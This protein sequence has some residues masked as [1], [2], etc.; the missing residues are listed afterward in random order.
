MVV[1]IEYDKLDGSRWLD[2]TL[3]LQ[4]CT[5]TILA[6]PAHPLIEMAVDRVMARLRRLAWKQGT[7]VSGI[8]AS[9]KEV[10]DS[11]G[12]A[13]FTEVVLEGLAQST[14]T[15][16]SHLNLTGLKTARLISDVLIL[17]INAFGSGQAH[18][19][20]GSPD[21]E[22]ALVQHMFAGSWKGNHDFPDEKS[23]IAE[24]E[25]KRTE[26]EMKREALRTQLEEEHRKQAIDKQKEE[27]AEVGVTGS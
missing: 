1:G 25:D 10:L 4:F 19:N 9:F 6:K 7:T 13:M 27:T 16:F 8:K 14:G 11:T 21:E 20:S 23:L 12:P 5:W 18:S 26:E 22:S 3:D 2:W 15:N 17:P 24:L